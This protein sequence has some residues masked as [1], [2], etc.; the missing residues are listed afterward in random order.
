MSAL[1]KAELVL[2]ADAEDR[3]RFFEKGTRHVVADDRITGVL[4][5]AGLITTVEGCAAT[6]Y[7]GA[8]LTDQGVARLAASLTPEEASVLE[9]LGRE[10]ASSYGECSGRAL[11]AL[12]G[13]DLAS[14]A[15]ADPRGRDYDAVSVTDRGFRYLAARLRASAGRA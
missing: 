3:L 5:A 2:P 8:S 10:D 14:V 9:W 11:D 1:P 6:G 15:A 4:R 12:L 13:R 7:L